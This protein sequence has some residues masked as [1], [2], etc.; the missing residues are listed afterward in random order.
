MMRSEIDRRAR[1]MPPVQYV[2]E[3]IYDPTEKHD[4][5]C[6]CPMCRCAWAGM[7]VEQRNAEEARS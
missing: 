2:A 3:A 1:R 5:R 7:T 4:I 6:D